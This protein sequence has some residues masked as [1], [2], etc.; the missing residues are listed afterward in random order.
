MTMNTD[1]AKRQLASAIASLDR[2]MEIC[3]D[4]MRDLDTQPSITIRDG[5]VGAAATSTEVVTD[6][7]IAELRRRAKAS[8]NPEARKAAAVLLT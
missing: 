6:A 2:A 8:A 4:I 1:D 3:R 5:S 7:V